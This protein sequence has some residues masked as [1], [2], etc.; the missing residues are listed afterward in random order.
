MNSYPTQT[1][2]CNVT[3]FTHEEFDARLTKTR[4]AMIERGLDS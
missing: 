3:V 1:H 2:E 4:A